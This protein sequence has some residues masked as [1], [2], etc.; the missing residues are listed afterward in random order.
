MRARASRPWL[1]RQGNRTIFSGETFRKPSVRYLVL[2]GCVWLMN[3]GIA[4]ADEP[5]PF[6]QGSKL[7]SRYNCQSCHAADT[8]LAGPSLSAIAHKYAEDPTAQQELEASVVNG[9][10]GKW[11]TESS[12]SASP[13]PAQDLHT[14][15][16]WIL[17]LR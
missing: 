16:K 10:S 11:G 15:V 9:S 17:S 12:M 1:Q 8:S 4:A 14:L 6:A 3:C 13:V 5:I 7:L 2:S